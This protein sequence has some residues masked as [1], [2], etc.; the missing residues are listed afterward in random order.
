MDKKYEKSIFKSKF[1]IDSLWKINV[2]QFNL[3][4]IITEY[5][6]PH[7]VNMHEWQST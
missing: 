3:I 2:F 1:K 6:I 4:Q 5:K 7:L